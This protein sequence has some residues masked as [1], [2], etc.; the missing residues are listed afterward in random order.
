MRRHCFSYCIA[1]LCTL[2][3]GW[4]T[5]VYSLEQSPL[6]QCIGEPSSSSLNNV[7]RD[8][9]AASKDADS[10]VLKKMLEPR[11]LSRHVYAKNMPPA[12]QTADLV[13]FAVNSARGNSILRDVIRRTWGSVATRMGMQIKFFVGRSD[14]M[15]GIEIEKAKHGDVVVLDVDESNFRGG[16]NLLSKK[17]MLLMQWL[18]KHLKKTTDFAV[19]VDDDVY[20]D[21]EAFAARVYKLKSEKMSTDKVSNMLYYG[22]INERSRPIKSETS[23]WYDPEFRSELYPPYAAGIFYML[24]RPCIE[25]IAANAGVFKQWRN[26]DASVGTWLYGTRVTRIH[27]GAVYPSRSYRSLTHTP[28]ALHMAMST[29]VKTSERKLRI[30]NKD[31]D[32]MFTASLMNAAHRHLQEYGTIIGVCKDSADTVDLK[33]ENANVVYMTVDEWVLGRM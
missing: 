4:W 22:Y 14:D 2:Q 12:G 16:Y 10:S 7:H 20:F 5:P 33:V 28:I 24:S 3:Q 8:H 6:V 15:L 17:T 25:F 32:A 31:F 9:A 18:E 29:N 11:L 1:L 26:E 19:K 30:K 13:F 27:D 23:K 21:V